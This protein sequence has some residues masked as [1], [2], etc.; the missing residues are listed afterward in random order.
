MV[1]NGILYQEKQYLKK[2]KK[3]FSN[4]GAVN[5]LI[6]FNGLNATLGSNVNTYVEAFTTNQS[7]FMQSPQSQSGM[8]LGQPTPNPYPTNPTNPSNNQSVTMQQINNQ[9]HTLQNQNKLQAINPAN[10]DNNLTTYSNQSEAVLS[11]NQLSDQ[12]IASFTSLTE[13]YNKLIQEYNTAQNNVINKSD[14]QVLSMNA[15]TNPYLNSNLEVSGGTVYYINNAGIAQPYYNNPLTTP[16]NQLSAF[17]SQS[18][19]TP[20]AITNLSNVT[21]DRNFI[22][23]TPQMQIGNYKYQQYSSG[24]EG[25]NVYANNS[26]ATTFTDSSFGG[27]FNTSIPSTQQSIGM[28]P[29]PDSVSGNYTFQTCQQAAYDSGSPFFSFN[30]SNPNSQNGNCY[31]ANNDA[32]F[33]IISQGPALNYTYTQLW[34]SNITNV[35]NSDMSGN[36]MGIDPAGNIVIYNSSNAAIWSSDSSNNSNT[37]PSNFIGCYQN[38]V[39]SLQP[40]TVEETRTSRVKTWWGGH[41]EVTKTFPVTKYKNVRTGINVNG[42]SNNTW[43]TCYQAA[44][45]NG[46]PYF[47]VG[48]INPATNTSPCFLSTDLSNII[49]GG[50]AVCQ[51]PIAGINYGDNGSI[52]VY[53]ATTAPLNTFLTLQD[54]G[55]VTAFTGI[56]L[57]DVQNVTWQLDMSG[58]QQMSN[59]YIINSATYSGYMQIGQTLQEGQSFC[60]PNATIFFT[61]QGGNLVLYTSSN[62]PKCYLMNSDGN[63]YY[64]GDN[65]MNAIYTMNNVGDPANLGN[66]GYVDQNAFLYPYSQN[67]VGKGN[68][69]TYMGNYDTSGTIIPYTNPSDGITSNYITGLDLSGSMQQCINIPNCN[70]FVMTTINGPD[71]SSIPATKFMSTAFATPFTS[72]GSYYIPRYP[73]PNAKLYIRNPTVNNSPYCN[74]SIAGINSTLYSNYQPN[75]TNSQMDMS[76]QCV[77]INTTNP[78]LEN[79]SQEINQLSTQIKEQQ[80]VLQNKTMTVNQQQQLNEIIL[81]R[82]F[83]EINTAQDV[84][85]KFKQSVVSA[86]NITNDSNIVVLRENQ[87]YILWSVLAISIAL[88]SIHVIR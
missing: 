46:S 58:Q 14:N 81:G 17:F 84:Q 55:I 9:I 36:Y 70:A 80:K 43:E 30:V 66:I 69:F 27:C 83:K 76:M 60:S 5:G 24:Y 31:L 86:Q 15:S 21:S 85:K 32:S 62:T 2:L 61:M 42:N 18:T 50:K 73:S 25:S 26:Q 49:A 38:T 47:G 12:E 82:Q 74:K 57:F 53:S 6:G 78:L 13:Q 71:N 59:Y 11:Q 48:P 37:S 4:N 23:T 44:Y 67:M 35:N 54:T 68:N 63:E 79:L 56:N 77:Q 72:S 1:K 65:S 39:T 40:Y 75:T 7:Q 28:N 33:N 87:N 88:I 29:A 16:G 45:D 34:S 10:P 20:T 3:S 52:A 22:Y 8:N 64:V 19:N 51:A 41:K